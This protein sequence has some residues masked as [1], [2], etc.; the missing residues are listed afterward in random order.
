MVS[1]LEYCQLLCQREKNSGG[2]TCVCTCVCMH[3]CVPTAVSEEESS[4]GHMSMPL[5]L[6]TRWLKLVM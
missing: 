3:M 1:Q 4:G 5:L 6:K 2:D